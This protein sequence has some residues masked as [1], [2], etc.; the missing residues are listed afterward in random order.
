MSA[1]RGVRLAETFLWNP[2]ENP[3]AVILSL[4]KDG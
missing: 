3:L 1:G 4:S 2:A